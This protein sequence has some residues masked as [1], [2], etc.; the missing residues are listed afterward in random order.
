MTPL[1]YEGSW[2][3]AEIAKL[4]RALQKVADLPITDRATK[5]ALVAIAKRRRRIALAALGA[6][7]AVVSKQ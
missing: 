6:K 5:A 7:S 1:R 2:F 3:T 4:R